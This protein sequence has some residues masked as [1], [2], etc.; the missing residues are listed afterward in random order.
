MKLFEFCSVELSIEGSASVLNVV[1]VCYQL[2]A[3][4]VSSVGSVQPGVT[5]DGPDSVGVS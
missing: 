1:N 2:T 5:S 3:V 4:P